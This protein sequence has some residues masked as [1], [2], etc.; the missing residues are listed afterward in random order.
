MWLIPEGFQEITIDP[1]VWEDGMQ[2]R[3]PMRHLI[4]P[5]AAREFVPILMWSFRRRGYTPTQLRR[6]RVPSMDE[7]MNTGVVKAW[8]PLKST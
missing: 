3:T 1:T 2:A 6:L 8:L 5:G 7:A 4:K